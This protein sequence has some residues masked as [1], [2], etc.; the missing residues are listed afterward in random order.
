[1]TCQS[2]SQQLSTKLGYTQSFTS[3]P[4]PRL[5][6]SQNKFSKWAEQNQVRFFRTHD[7]NYVED[8]DHW[9]MC[10]YFEGTIEGSYAK[11]EYYNGQYRYSVVSTQLDLSVA[12]VVFSNLS[13]MLNAKCQAKAKF[14]QMQDSFYAW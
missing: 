6:T 14:Q 8:D 3:R 13:Q 11:I 5:L 2:L 7:E 1:M 12:T 10:F 4:K 9:G